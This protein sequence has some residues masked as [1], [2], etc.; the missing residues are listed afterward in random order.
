MKSVSAYYFWIYKINSSDSVTYRK[1][2]QN[3]YF[4]PEILQYI[5]RWAKNCLREVVKD[6]CET[7]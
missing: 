2:L 3:P 7:L 4:S 5:K 6:G 1:S